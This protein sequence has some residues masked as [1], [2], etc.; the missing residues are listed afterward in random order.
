M[1]L[2]K[3]IVIFLSLAMTLSFTMNSFAL[4]TKLHPDDAT[5]E[6]VEIYHNLFKKTYTKAPNPLKADKNIYPLSG[7]VL[8]G[9]YTKEIIDYQIDVLGWELLGTARGI[10]YDSKYDKDRT[11][12]YKALVGKIEL[13]DRAI[14]YFETERPDVNIAEVYL[15]LAGLYDGE[16]DPKEKDLRNIVI[17]FL[18]SFDYKNVSEEEKLQNIIKFIGSK[19]HYVA[20]RSP[21]EVYDRTNTYIGTAWSLFMTGEGSCDSFDDAVQLLGRVVGLSVLRCVNTEVYVKVND[22][23][24]APFIDGS[25]I[26]P[27]ETDI[28]KMNI[29]EGVSV[30]EEYLLQYNKWN[31]YEKY[32]NR[33]LT[34]CAYDI[35]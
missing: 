31:T 6:Q 35:E 26:T 24:Y 16:L 30:S 8:Y 10:D 9:I 27:N 13:P 25:Q 32:E 18:N 34:G 3:L 7:E 23:W 1:K 21:L 14:D 12:I 11:N 17:E 20:V 19:G 33:I 5:K 4:M 2:K 15:D 22:K 29:V 28:E